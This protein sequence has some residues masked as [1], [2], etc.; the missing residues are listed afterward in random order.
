MIPLEG[1]DLSLLRPDVKLIVEKMSPVQIDIA[2]MI[3]SEKTDGK[4]TTRYGDGPGRWYY[5]PEI[6]SFPML[7]FATKPG[8]FA[9]QANLRDPQNPDEPLLK[10]FLN[11]RGASPECYQLM[12]AGIAAKV[13]GNPRHKE[14]KYITGIPNTGPLIGRPLARILNKPYIDILEKTGDDKK[15]FIPREKFENGEFRPK[16]GEVA[17]MV[18]DVVTKKTTKVLAEEAANSGGFVVGVHG[19]VVD[20][21]DGGFEE[22]TLEKKVI[23]A[24][25]RSTQIFALAYVDG[26]LDDEKY[27]NIVG[28]IERRRIARIKK[29]IDQR[30]ASKYPSLAVA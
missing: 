30:F 22:M 28:D 12:A 5:V 9:G 4:L 2:R 13:K 3:M 23:V 8:E 19:V 15:P 24:A 1:K 6:G 29:R 27:D 18:D 10:Y 14:V 11:L 16:E 21:Q 17:L 25:L 7:T 20:R 26:K